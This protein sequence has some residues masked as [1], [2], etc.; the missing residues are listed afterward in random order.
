MNITQFKVKQ[1][2]DFQDFLLDGTES[3]NSFAVKIFEAIPDW[4]ELLKTQPLEFTQMVNSL[5]DFY[6]EVIEDIHDKY[7]P[8]QP[9]IGGTTSFIYSHDGKVI[10]CQTIEDFSMTHNVTSE[11]EITSKMKELESKPY[12]TLSNVLFNYLSL[13]FLEFSDAEQFTNID[14]VKEYLENEFVDLF[15]EA[16]VSFDLSL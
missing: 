7:I 6:T 5:E 12:E 8:V 10:V 13:D 16:Y 14:D 3:F 11:E 4:M 15:S 9:L 2:K 1:M